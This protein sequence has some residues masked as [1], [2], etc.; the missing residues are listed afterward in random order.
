MAATNIDTLNNTL[1]KKYISFFK[2]VSFLK[3][4]LL[5]S[6]NQIKLVK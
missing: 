1:N 3:Q 5:F 4:L 6:M 2:A